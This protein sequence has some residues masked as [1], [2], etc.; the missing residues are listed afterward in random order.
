MVAY[1]TVITAL[2]VTTC[3]DTLKGTYLERFVSRNAPSSRSTYA[4][5]SV[6]I[7]SSESLERSEFDSIVRRGIPTIFR[8]VAF[9]WDDMR[10]LSCSE[11]GRRWPEARMRAEY[12]GSADEV[13]VEL[14]DQASWATNMRPVQGVNSPSVDSSPDDPLSRP[15]VGPY[16]LHVKDRVKRAMKHEIAKMFPGLP[17]TRSMDSLLI[18]AQTRDSME[19]WFQ[20]IGGGTFAHNDGYC[21][22]VFSVQLRGSKKWSFMLTPEVHKLSR[23]IFDEFDSGIYESVH[24]WVPDFEVVLEA[25][26][27]VLFPPGY[28]H[29]TRTISGPSDKDVCGTSVTFN[30]P[31]PMPSRLVRRFLNRFSTSLEISHCMPRWESFVTMNTTLVDWTADVGG[32]DRGS[33]AK[34]ITRNIFSAVDFDRNGQISLE[35]LEEYFL[36]DPTD[37]AIASFYDSVSHERFGDLMLMFSPGAELTPD[38]VREGLRVRAK[39]TLDMWDVNEDG[40]AS[41]DEVNEVIEFF[42]YHSV[43][44]GLVDKAIRPIDRETGEKYH[45]P[46]GSEVFASRLEL[47]EE[48]LE[49]LFPEKGGEDPEDC[50]EPRDEL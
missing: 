45:I 26:D 37:P 38:M 7:E 44:T 43:K 41:T 15:S 6:E 17:W 16:V 1:L 47:V 19:F 33:L 4:I 2:G 20:P 12:T 29:E 3:T 46:I 39:D 34:T 36:R 14:G 40:E 10:N 22:S 35:E 30:L 21:H 18:S 13:M 28:M 27:G 8:N 9:D 50:E 48:I 42:Q 11:F 31:I 24:K 25:G 32:G 49:E 5:P 23:D